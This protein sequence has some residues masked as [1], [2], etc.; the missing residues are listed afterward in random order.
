MD[1]GSIKAFVA[2]KSTISKVKR[3]AKS[4]S[5]GVSLRLSHTFFISLGRFVNS[6]KRVM[7]SAHMLF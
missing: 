7:D 2:G 6:S 1:G 3:L 4:G 5:L